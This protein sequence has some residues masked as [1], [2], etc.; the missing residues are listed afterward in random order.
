MKKN[1]KTKNIY[2]LLNK[3]FRCPYC[4]REHLIP[5]RFV[6]KDIEINQI[7]S[8]IKKIAN[9]KRI[10]LLCDEITCEVAGRDIEK[11][12]KKNKWTCDMVV[13]KPFN[14][15]RVHADE[16]YF[17]QIINHSKDKD[18]ILTIGAGSITDMG[19]YVGDRIGVPVASFPTAP[20]MN[21]YTSSVVA[22][23]K[24]GLKVA[25]KAKPPIGVLINKKIIAG[26][27]EELIKAGF[28]DS[29]AKCYSNADW[30]LSSVLTKGYFC[31]LPL[32]IVSEAEKEYINKGK[33]VVNRDKK[34]IDALMDGLLNGGFSMVIA[35]SSSPASGGEH[36]ISHYLDME[37]GYRNIESYSFHGLQVGLGII[38]VSKIYDRLQKMSKEEIQKRLGLYK[39]N[40]YEETIRDAFKD[41]FDIVWNEFKKKQKVMEKL[42]VSLV[43]NWDKI[44]KEI[45]PLVYPYK[46]MKEY[47]LNAG[48][49]THFNEIGINKKLA[50][51]TIMNA[52]FIRERLTIL[53]IADEIGIL[54]EIADKAE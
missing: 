8:L 48:C 25:I 47:L 1:F 5:I 54:K 33:E 10:L 6:E 18:V 45:L 17:P 4:N 43:K 24:K 36:L 51:E 28:A 3:K 39:N 46:K 38:T 37:A 50:Y 27:P 9:N 14:T 30:K 53:D 31:P 32:E 44:K 20:S 34:C 40:S 23:I 16:K 22:F 7:P 42:P 41:R 2:S 21:G 11:T 29:L 52:R 19:K 15:G 12:F 35:G 49:P 26:A 13:L